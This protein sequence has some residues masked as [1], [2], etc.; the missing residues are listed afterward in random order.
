MGH[1]ATGR[2]DQGL[3]SAMGPTTGIPRRRW[4]PGS[5]RRSKRGLPLCSALLRKL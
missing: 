2:G 5:S 1:E 3:S 4:P